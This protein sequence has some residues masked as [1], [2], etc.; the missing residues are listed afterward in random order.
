[1]KP[2]DIVRHKS[3]KIGVICHDLPG[4][5]RCGLPGDTTIQFEGDSHVTELPPIE[6]ETIGKESAVPNLKGCGA[7]RGAECCIFLVVNGPKL[8][9]QRHGPMRFDLLFKSRMVSDRRPVELYPDCM[10]FMGE[11]P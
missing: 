1:M 8:E 9:C 5:L 3:G 2:G 4:Y 6:F 7:G 10:K 11:K